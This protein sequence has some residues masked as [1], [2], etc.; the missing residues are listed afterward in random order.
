MRPTL[1]IPVLR[2]IGH[3]TVNFDQQINLYLTKGCKKQPSIAKVKSRMTKDYK[4]FK[5]TITQTQRENG[6]V[7]LQFTNT[8]RVATRC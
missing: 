8:L 2:I 4:N 7:L 3:P 6:Y 1:L 5:L